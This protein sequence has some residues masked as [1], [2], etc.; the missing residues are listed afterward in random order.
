[1][2]TRR[3]LL[4]C[5][6]LTCFPACWASCDDE[7][8]ANDVE[9]RRAKQLISLAEKV[10]RGG[11]SDKAFAVYCQACSRDRSLVDGKMLD[12]FERAGR[13]LELVPAIEA[14]TWEMEERSQILLISRRLI[15]NESTRDKGSEFL[16]QIWDRH[17]AMRKDLT[18]YLQARTWAKVNDPAY[19]I[20]DKIIPRDVATEGDGWSRFAKKNY[21]ALCGDPVGTL[22]DASMVL[23][24]NEEAARG[25]AVEVQDLVDQHPHWKGGWALLCFL[26][27]KS[28]DR[29]R[30]I[31]LFQQ[32]LEDHQRSP[33]P[34]ANAELL[35]SVMH[36]LDPAYDPFLIELCEISLETRTKNLFASVLPE[37]MKLYGKANRHA[38]AMML[39]RRLVD[40]EFDFN[41]ASQ[42]SHGVQKAYLALIDIG[43]PVEALLL[44]GQLDTGFRNSY[45]ASDSGH[46]SLRVPLAEAEQRAVSEVTPR[47]VLEALD[48]GAF[49]EPRFGF[50][51]AEVVSTTILPCVASSPLDLVLSARQEARF[52]PAIYSAT[53]TIFKAAV[54]TQKDGEVSD[55]NQ[56][57]QRVFQMSQ[58]HPTCLE[59]AIATTCLAFYRNDISAAKSRLERLIVLRDELAKSNRIDDRALWPVAREAVA[60]EATKDIG[61]D[62]AEYVL[63]TA[64]DTEWEPVLVQERNSSASE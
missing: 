15:L 29:K 7:L 1:M 27:A 46:W 14:H 48:R 57:D 60:H 59:A 32:L 6:L 19:F 21:W 4:A 12:L 63:L 44:T 47:V 58:Q 45:G 28:G 41:G 49:S 34:A 43:R 18:R 13:L 56:L 17:V 5:L 40:S 51:E 3:F 10:A 52:K 62:L 25:L 8:K 16:K 61:E 20:R 53:L 24:Q 42:K 36:G 11:N 55:S 23:Q 33:I 54:S 30:A 2:D 35:A 64:K 9:K 39:A 22:V 31:E 26:E 37:L 38:E 50:A